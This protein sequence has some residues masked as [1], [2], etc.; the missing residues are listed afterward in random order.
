MQAEPEL[1]EERKAI[2]LAR[3]RGEGRIV[4]RLA[5]NELGVSVDTIR[6]DLLQLEEA[7]SLRRVHGG[8]VP[9]ASLP[10]SFSER[11]DDP[12]PETDTIARLIVD[13]L[14]DGQ[15]IGLDAGTTGVAIA[16]V[17]PTNLRLTIVTT[18]LPAAVALAPHCE[19]RVV[20]AG[21]Q[22]DRTWMALT[23]PEAVRTIGSFRFDL[24]VVGVC[25]IHP[26]HGLT[27]NSLDEVETKRAWIDA[28]AE[29]IVPIT[30]DKLD[31]V[32][33]FVV[34]PLH[35][36]ATI[37]HAGALTARALRPYEKHGVLLL[38]S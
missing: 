33:P 1:S 37:A 22:F 20:V 10:N 4:T 2:L 17:L 13:R 21:G 27:T 26:D 18:N 19:V 12:S 23:G 5:A 14:H 28:A 38:R 9:P 30:T 6:R 25:A 36:I 35:H 24:A 31:R 11:A 15:V 16:R 34:S 8:A 7:R 29:T 3:L 32:A